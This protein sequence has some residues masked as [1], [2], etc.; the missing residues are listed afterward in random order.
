MLRTAAALAVVALLGA[1]LPAAA[2][3][4][5]PKAVITDES[6]LPR[7][8]YPL[9]VA[10]S[11]LLTGDAAAFAPLAAAVGKD[12]DAVLSDDDIRDPGVMAEYLS[13]QLAVRQLT[14]DAAGVRATVAA[15]R[16]N[17]PKAARK[18][19][20][21]RI[22]LAALAAQAAGPNGAEA[23]F[24]A[25][26]R[27][28]VDA[29]PWGLV[30][31]QIKSSYG[32][33]QTVTRDALIG[34]IIHEFDPIWAKSGNL[35]GA[36]ARVLV[37]TRA[38]MLFALPYLAAD[39]PV[40]H[41]YIAAHNVVRRDIWPAREVTLAPAQ[42]RAPVAIGIWDSGVD[43]RDYPGRMF[44]DRAG[45][46]GLG[47][48]PDGTRSSREL[49]PLPAFVAA[50]YPALV[51][52]LAGRSDLQIG[53]DTPDAQSFIAYERALTPYQAAESERYF[54]Q[55]GEYVHGSHVA[56]IAARGNAGARLVVLRFDDEL[57][58]QMAFAPSVTWA[59]RMAGNFARLA[60]YVRAHN[61]HV[62]NCSWGDQVSEFE[63]W[64]A[65]RTTIA[66]P[67]AR[68]ALAQ[69]LYGIWR[70]AVQ[71]AIATTPGT[72][73]VISAG[74]SNTSATFGGSVPSSFTNPNV[75][76]V[77]AVDQAGDPTGFTSYGPTVA[78]YADG[79][80]VP[81]D[82]PGGYTVPLSGTSMAAPGVTNLAAKLLALDPQL[83]PRALRALIVAGATRSADGKLLLV[84]EQRSV[85]LL[86]R[87]LRG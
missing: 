4:A 2:Q 74:N 27:A 71:R 59:R 64:I 76:V 13:A 11:V 7:V 1:M 63:Q 67:A 40:L 61:V 77:G 26:D 3:T 33:E 52:L 10:P 53:A 20:D 86:R 65:K 81:S 82:V 46:H 54:D 16:A 78:V 48:D 69:R 23:A 38:F 84:D 79:L 39:V 55:I 47:F 17:E 18:L 49:Y 9:A 32:G 36:S 12:V 42:I 8:A 75:L 56:G 83:S 68:K 28:A 73:Y 43:P 45:H 30:Q 25:A 66:D 58:G 44:V 22:A 51:R 80:H 87:R 37:E 15:I 57:D 41:A 62:V 85:A 72:L 29:L 31:A 24:V 50:R 14:G 70:A 5:A 35:D 21:G 34:D 19:L 60:A 6:Q